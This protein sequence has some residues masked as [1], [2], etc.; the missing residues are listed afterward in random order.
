MLSSGPLFSRL[1]FYFT[2]A[3]AYWYSVALT[4]HLPHL[5]GTSRRDRN[6]RPPKCSQGQSTV[7]RSSDGDAIQRR[8]RCDD[9][10]SRFIAYAFARLSI[11]NKRLDSGSRIRGFETSKAFAR[12]PIMSKS[13]LY[14]CA[15]ACVHSFLS[16]AFFARAANSF[17]GSNLYYAAGLSDDEANTLFQYVFGNQS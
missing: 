12:G 8:C 6:A 4:S 15:F 13:L 17:A 7:P 2:C 10:A 14:L 1:S 3:H 9:V 16:S 11:R 5:P